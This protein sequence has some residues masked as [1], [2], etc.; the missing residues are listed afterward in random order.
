MSED[1]RKW[2]GKGPTGGWDRYNSKG[3]KAGKCG[4]S[5]EGSKYAACL[6]N[7]KAAKLG[8]DGRASFVKRKQTAQSKAG[9]S[10]KG[11][12]QKKGQKPV[13]VK[14][15]ASE[16]INELKLNDLVN[17]RFSIE[18]GSGTTTGNWSNE[19]LIEK[20]KEAI[21]H[22]LF[23]R[24]FYYNWTEL[25]KEYNSIFEKE[26]LSPMI[27]NIDRTLKEFFILKGST[28]V[29]RLEG[30]NAQK[31]IDKWFQTKK[32]ISNE[33]KSDYYSYRKKYAGVTLRESV[34]E[35]W[36][37]KYKNSIDCNNP[38]GFSQKAHCAGKNENKSNNIDEAIH[39]EVYREFMQACNDAGLNSFQIFG[40]HVLVYILTLGA[41][42]VTILSAL[43]IAQ[44]AKDAKDTFNNWNAGRK[45]NPEKVK[46]IV[47][48]FENKVNKLEGGRKK[49]FQ[50]IINKMKKTNPE[51][52]SALVSINKDLEYYA[53]AYG[54]KEE[55]MNEV[56]A[57][58][59]EPKRVEAFLNKYPKVEELMQKIVDKVK[60]VDRGYQIFLHYKDDKGQERYFGG[61][62]DTQSK[63]SNVKGLGR[64]ALNKTG[65]SFNSK[66]SYKYEWNG[67]MDY[68]TWGE[69]FQYVWNNKN[70]SMNLE[71]K[72]NLFLE[73]NVPTDPQKWAASIAA[74]KKKFDVYPSAY[75][76]GWAA[77][78][79]K[80]K[81]GTWKSAD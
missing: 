78:N 65:K 68:P 71:E 21:K 81:G 31:W 15:G 70:E 59:I 39:P 62:K 77:K 23:D 26:T 38:K 55:S 56:A 40:L 44:L 4:D 48:D 47:K 18:V 7:E 33:L 17:T 2:F 14:T 63:S 27:K 19:E 80:E 57:R 60:D 5:E 58:Y 41:T 11:G 75:A 6:S 12:E 3:E 10:K 25:G 24:E 28:L 76:N 22:N 34:K 46:A 42:G 69:L 8:K 49:F 64:T 67:K 37:Q 20:L 52:K 51:N 9:D 30:S 35:D 72:L 66:T 1:L 29:F 36:S 32:S 61:K 45:L 54:I 50:G 73:K 13:F 74:A 43:G 79:Y 16:D 53:K